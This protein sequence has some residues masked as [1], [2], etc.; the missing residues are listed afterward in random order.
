M[1]P[2]LFWRFV[3]YR[4]LSANHSIER[5]LILN[6]EAWVL[7]LALTSPPPHSLVTTAHAW[8]ICVSFIH[9]N[10]AGSWAMKEE[11]DW[12]DSVQQAL[13]ENYGRFDLLI[14]SLISE[15]HS[16]WADLFLSSHL[17]LVCRQAWG[18][19]LSS[20]FELW[21]C[22][23]GFHG[24]WATAPA[25]FTPCPVSQV[26]FLLPC[27]TWHSLRTEAFYSMQNLAQW[28]VQR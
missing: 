18:P 11:V 13:T 22:R 25:L 24:T 20:T 26:T 15:K 28:L 8:S 12:N 1:N 14:L 7:L 21:V 3:S 4:G 6:E 23:S 2:D 9:P 10:K 27:Q 17:V 19:L 16:S 5:C